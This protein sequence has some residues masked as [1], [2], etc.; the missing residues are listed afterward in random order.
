MFEGLIQFI[1]Q[2]SSRSNQIVERRPIRHAGAEV[3]AVLLQFGGRI[4]A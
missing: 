3:I 1:E 2:A 4:R